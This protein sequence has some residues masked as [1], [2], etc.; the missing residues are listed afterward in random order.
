MP[1]IAA[2]AVTA[3]YEDTQAES[4]TST[5]TSFV[6]IPNSSL[7]VTLA[8]GDLVIIT[9]SF[10]YVGLERLTTSGSVQGTVALLR[11]STVL[12]AGAVG[13]LGDAVAASD[14][15]HWPVMLSWTESPGAGTHTYKLQFRVI[16]ANM[17]VSV[18]DRTLLVAVW[19]R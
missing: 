11:G 8:A 1:I 19:K 12:A 4:Q 17:R 16:G 3:I 18:A 14:L 15:R 7:A 5:S 9:A 2:N 13:W 10:L 6:D